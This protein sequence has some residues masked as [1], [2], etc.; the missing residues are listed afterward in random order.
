MVG[1]Q[2]A[3]YAAHDPRSARPRQLETQVEA[4]KSDARRAPDQRKRRSE[5]LL[6]CWGW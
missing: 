5:A 2:R 3:A 6:S 1:M 4:G